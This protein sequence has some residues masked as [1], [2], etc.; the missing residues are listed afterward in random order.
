[1]LASRPPSD[2][3]C[4]MNTAIPGPAASEAVIAL[5][6]LTVRRY[7]LGMVF[8][9]IWASGYVLLPFVLGKSLAAPGWLVTLTVTMETTGMLLALYWGQLMVSGGRRRAL[10][11]GGLSGR[12]IMLATFAVTTAGH[13]ALLVC[14]VHMFS[15]LVYPAQ[16]GILQANIRTERRGRVFGWGA[17]VL[18]LTM[19]LASIIVGRLLDSDPGSFR[20]IYPVFGVLGFV[21]PLILS[22]LPRPEGDLTHDPSHV[23]TVPRL[24]LGPVR[25]KRLAGALVTPF[26]E[27]ATT[28]RNDRAF[29][30]FEANFMIYGIAFMMLVPVVPLFFINELNL[31]YRQISSARV[32]IAS[33]GVALLSPLAGRLM[34]RM[35]P[36]RLSAISNAVISL[37]PISL[38]LG[39]LLL[40]AQPAL[41]AYLAFGVYSIGMAG[42]NVT[43]NM[44]SI[45]FAPPGQGGYYQGIHVAMVGIR[46]LVGPALGF[47]VLHFLGYR[48]VF[49]LAA[50]IFL[51]AAGSSVL[52]G[53]RMDRGGF[54]PGPLR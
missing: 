29:L 27:A 46:G 3:H 12:V 7:L 4:A 37:Y 16:N 13:F 52:L 31:N 38:A 26:R 51:T 21:Y 47:T 20:I 35:N 40:P 53:R 1:M 30:W 50:L 45:S 8:Q 41:G 19:A 23:F 2:D 48:E 39:A 44:G 15:A 5:E 9:G 49:V 18:N 43:W 32:L 11:W 42:V 28:F 10:F 14:V 25:L 36:V 22:R 34:D 33:L 17:L 24:P 6:K 54:S